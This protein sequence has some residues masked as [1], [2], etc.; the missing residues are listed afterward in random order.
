MILKRSQNLKL[1]MKNIAQFLEKK[2]SI[3]E[4][5]NILE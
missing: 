5:K 3:G 1:A 4:R 2:G